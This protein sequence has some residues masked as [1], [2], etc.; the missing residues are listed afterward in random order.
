VSGSLADVEVS[1]PGRRRPP[2]PPGAVKRRFRPKFHY[3]LIVCGLRGHVLVG[4]D[5]EYVDPADS[6]FVR[7]YDGTRWYRCLRCDAWLPMPPPLKPRRRVVP[8]RD[9]VVLPTRGRALRDKIVLRLIAIDRAIHFLILGSLAALAFVLADH[10]EQLVKLI[11]RIN[12][13]FFGTADNPHG[14][15]GGFLG[16]TERL[17]TLDTTTFRLIGVAAAA[18]ALL[19]GT[20]AVGL[21]L[22][23]RWAEYLTFVATALFVPYE[24]YELSEKI[25]VIRVGALVVNVAILLYLL[26]AKRLFGLRGG[27]AADRAAREADSGWDAFEELTPGTFKR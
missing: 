24:I 4:T 5:A 8:G 12:V 10:R 14:R 23:R 6:A 27:A 25:T 7:T 19:E 20:E 17:L 26:V 11:D 15:P 2:H 21:W 16:D 13:F 3:E 22:Q 1:P 18:Y 9:E